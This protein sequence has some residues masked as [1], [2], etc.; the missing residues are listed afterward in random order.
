[1][2][3]AWRRGTASATLTPLGITDDAAAFAMLSMFAGGPAELARFGDDAPVQTDDRTALEYSA[4]QAIYGRTVGDNAA[5]IRHLGAQPPPSVKALLDA[6]TDAQWTSRGAMLLK[7]EAFGLAY[8]AFRRAATLNSGNP[9]AL[10]GL[11]DA[12]A[13]MRGG[14]DEREL[15][16]SIAAREP[17]NVA[18][19]LELS[20]V[21]A[22]SGN[23]DAAAAA[24]SE[25]MRISPDEGRAAEQLASVLA[26]AGD[27]ERLA[28]ISNA[29]LARYPNRPDSHYYRGSALF[30]R[31]KPEEALVEA[32]RVIAIDPGHARAQN[33]LGAACATLGR[34]DCA[35]AAFQASI[36]ANPRDASTYV[37][38][39]MFRLQSGNPH[40]AADAFAEAL[41]LSPALEAAR[42]GLA[43]ARTQLSGR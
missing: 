6:A 15:L 1:M 40:G 4:P 21:L 23:Y 14:N 37:N 9:A 18:V 7:A 28:E 31:G 10:A 30:M 38:L 35:E 25:A 41:A 36:R 43:Q 22:S 19:R 16:T 24:A 29:L 32:Q 5:A 27:G 34:R 20:R 26:D 3:R 13:G 42:S 33:L 39:G 8:D 11:S 12:A 17:A 2:P